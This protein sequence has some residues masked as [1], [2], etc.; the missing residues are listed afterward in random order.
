MTFDELKDAVYKAGVIGAGGAGFPTHIK[1]VK[2]MDYL[3][4][5]GA[6]CEPLI[7]TDYEL[8]EH[9]GEAI[10]KVIRQMLE[11]LQIKKAVWGIKKKHQKLIDKLSAMT[12]LNANI[13]ICAL[14]NIYP[15]G[16]ELTLIYHCTGRIVAK[17]KL[18]SSQKIIE[19]NVETLL[20]IYKVL[21]EKQ[22]VTEKYVM[23]GGAVEESLILK[24]PIGTPFRELIKQVKP[25]DS[26]YELLVGGPMMG[27][28]GS[29]DDYVTKTTKAILLFPKESELYR[30][31]Q[32]IDWNSMKRVM[33]SC[34]QCQMC[35]DL[36]PRNKLGHQVEPH[37][38][39][40]AFANGLLS[41]S[42]ALKT[43]L[44]CCGCNICSY[45]ACHHDLMPSQ[46]MM[47]VKQ[48]LLKNG[49]RP[50]EEPTDV[51]VGAKVHVPAD[52][53]LDKLSI[54]L[55]DKHARWI[56]EPLNV[57]RVYLSCVAHVGKPAI[58]IVKV[59]E[60]VFKGK[61]VATASEDGISTNLHSSI[62][63]VVSSVT[64]QE[65]VIERGRLR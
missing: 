36:C 22:P 35:T 5:N 29:K 46:F 20:N 51:K 2:D 11:T 9:Y 14:P 27:S 54:R 65:I 44:G 4:I 61:L 8:M 6:E 38:L 26:D 17:G 19:L 16:D 45:F 31:K 1:L 39:M 47:T 56:E 41:Q 49:I 10:L 52:R 53:L 23:I 40:N 13:E 32:V 57:E 50:H 59:G 33:S 48:E 34:S 24:V 62:N 28:F 25:L 21:Y 42:G 60:E 30:I 64:K 55:Y 15:A 63:G 43:A 58:P 12:Q 18:P 37:K 7:Y 3:V